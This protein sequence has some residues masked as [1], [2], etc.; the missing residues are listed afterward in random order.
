MIVKSGGSK[1]VKANFRL[2]TE[3]KTREPVMEAENSKSYTIITAQCT[4][5]LLLL[6]K[7]RLP[8]KILPSEWL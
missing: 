8:E 4:N 3:G 7:Q 5:G 2:H 6:Y 1:G